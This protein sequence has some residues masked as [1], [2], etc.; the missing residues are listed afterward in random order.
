MD[1]D[2]AKFPEDQ[3][4]L[5]NRNATER[6]ENEPNCCRGAGEQFLR[7]HGANQHSFTVETH[8]VTEPTNGQN[9]VPECGLTSFGLFW[10][11]LDWLQSTG[12]GVISTW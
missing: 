5:S 10:P 8:T 9:A 1:K 12:S 11:D 4:F 2:A 7:V 3:H 6:I